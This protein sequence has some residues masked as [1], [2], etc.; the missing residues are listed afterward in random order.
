MANKKNTDS[1]AVAIA[2]DPAVSK[3][4]QILLIEILQHYKM[5]T[6]DNTKRMTRKDGW[7]D[8]TDAYYGK[9]PNDW[10]YLSR[11]VDPRIRTSLIEKNAR[12]LNAKLRGKIIPRNDGSTV[13]A[14][15]QNALIDQQWDAANDGGSMLTKFEVCDM[16]TRLYGSKFGYVYWK[17]ETDENGDVVFEGNEL[18]P[19][20]I[21]DSGIDPTANNIHDAKWFQMRTYEKLED[22]LATTDAEGKPLYKNLDKVKTQ[23]AAKMSLTRSS[24]RTTDYVPRIKTLKGLQDHTGEDLAYPV[25]KKVTEFR[26]DRFITFLPDYNLIIADTANPFVHKRIPIAQLKYYPL[27]DEPLGES[28]VEAVLPIWRAIQ[29]TVCAYLDEMILKIRPPLK[30]VENAARIETIQYGPEAQWLVDRQDAVEEMS[31]TGNSQQYFQT[32]YTALTAA[33]NI[34]MGDLSQGKSNVDPFRSNPKTATEINASMVQQNARDQKNQNDL[35]DFIEDIMSMWISNNRQFLFSNPEKIE[36]VIRVVGKSKFAHL[37]AMGMDQTEVPQEVMQ[38]IADIIN[39]HPQIT[40]IQL[41][42]LLKAGEIPKYPVVLN[43]NEKNPEKIKLKAKMRISEMGDSADVSITSEDLVGQY[44]YI[45]DVKSMS[46]GASQERQKARDQIIQAVQNPAIAQ[47]LY[48]EGYRLSVKDVLEKSFEDAGYTDAE[49]LFQPIGSGGMMGTGMIK[50]TMNFK[51]LP[52]DIQQQM[53]QRAGYQPS[54]QAVQPQ[55]QISTQPTQ[56]TQQAQGLTN[57]SASM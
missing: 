40:D 1:Q 55:A 22:L 30:I 48:I 17:Y 28:E 39:Q 37:Q 14:A 24:T 15:L 7:N 50:E 57:P 5:W 49:T 26:N 34:A 31:S 33:F 11:V 20:D 12:L 8:I 52:P 43:P 54:Q 3:D 56:A 36:H 4:D 13:G 53:E 44:S 35:A 21:R 51:D 6:E 45:A 18:L 16:D 41:Q 9:L 29:A 32:T 46:I 25:V 38:T 47:S 10:P 19:L 2:I 23:I 42:Q 27:Q